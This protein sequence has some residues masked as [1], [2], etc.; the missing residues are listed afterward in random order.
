MNKGY[1]MKHLMKNS[2]FL[3]ALLL[4]ASSCSKEEFAVN[5]GT[6]TSSTSAV[7]T[8]TSQSCAQSTLISPKV[9]ILMVWDNSS[10]FNFV[11]SAT[12]SSMTNLITT[13][14]ENFDYHILSVPLVPANTANLYEASLVVKSKTGLTGSAATIANLDKTSAV[15]NLAFTQGVGSAERGV[16][17]VTEVIQNN[18]SN[19]IFRNDA[20]TIIVIM[21]NEDDKGCEIDT[22]QS[23]CSA[24]DKGIYTTKRKAKL[25]CLR[26]NA[27][28]SSYSCSDLGVTSNLNSTMMRFINISPLTMCT[29]GFNKTNSIYRDV[30]KALYEAPY[31]N[32]WPTSNDDLSPDLA[33]YPDSY[34]LCSIDFSHIFDGVNTAIKQ[35]LLKH[36]YDYWPV[37]DSSAS[38][39]PD[40]IRVVRSDGKIL[41]NRAANTTATDG[42]ELILDS[43]G[44]AA[45]LTNQNTRYEPTAGEPYTGKMIKLYGSESDDKIVYPDCL[46]VTYSAVKTT[47]GYLYLSYG[48]PAESTIEV[49]LNGSVVP[50]STTN[51]WDYMGLQYISALDSTLKVVDLPSGATSGYIIRFNGTYKKTNSTANTYTVYYNSK[52]Q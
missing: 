42:Y 5:K 10:S 44:N 36:K 43:S 25:L 17:R 30:A 35:T 19:G 49:R 34:N 12:K 15:A 2:L 13:V 4:I 26:G 14:S 46:T 45:T 3:I 24:Y 27:N 23:S 48:E 29:S 32:G 21:S 22:G 9:D 38:V 51:G 41:T 39:D 47:I 11:T 50:K 7:T 18:R 8:T 40:S 20:Y 37:A 28:A 1:F 31:T 16:D 33:G 6:Q 52:G